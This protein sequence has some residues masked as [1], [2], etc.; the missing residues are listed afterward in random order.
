[1][2]TSGNENKA[3]QELRDEVVKL[4]SRGYRLTGWAVKLG[5]ATLAAVVIG[6]VMTWLAH[7]ALP[8]ETLKEID[9]PASVLN[10]FSTS[11][12]HSSS[13]GGQSSSDLPFVAVSDQL[14]GMTSFMVGPVAFVLGTL[15]LF[16]C[17]FLMIF[18]GELGSLSSLARMGAAAGVMIIASNTVSAITGSDNTSQ[19]TAEPSPRIA[20]MEAVDKKLLNIIER[21]LPARQTL[22]TDYVRAQVQLLSKQ[23]DSQVELYKRVSSGL[24]GKPDFTPDEKVAYLIDEAAFNQAKTDI[25][26]KY[27]D[28]RMQHSAAR[29]AWAKVAFNLSAI[30]LILTVAIGWLARSLAKRVHRIDAELAKELDAKRKK[31]T[32]AAT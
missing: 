15:L 17:G 28:E 12:P 25:A 9:V 8:V 32:P 24:A 4:Y 16:G 2:T 3:D 18:G 23:K 5:L 11:I 1:M 26:R 13:E 27:L 30:L 29:S 6:G 31:L 21:E 14:T 10:S 19:G 20:F 7:T 22:D